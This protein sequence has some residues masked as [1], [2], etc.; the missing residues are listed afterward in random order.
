MKLKLLVIL[1]H[2]SILVCAQDKSTGRIVD[3]QTGDPIEFVTIYDKTSENHAHTDVNGNFVLKEVSAG[4]SILISMVGYTRVQFIANKETNWN[5]KMEPAPIELGQVVIMSDINA[6]SRISDVQLKLNPV[7]S[8]QEILR[9]VPGL[10]IS[11]HAGGG[12]AEQIFLR[13]FDIDHGTDIQIT[14]DGIPVNMVSHAHGQG[15]ADLHFLIPETVK[16]IDFG[17]GPYY[18]QKGNFTTA[19][20]VNFKT[21]DRIDGN[22]IKLEG[23]SFNTSRMVS[24]ID[25]FSGSGNSDGYLATE[26]LMTDGPFDS[27]QNFNRLNIFGKYT[28]Q[29]NNNFLKVQVSNFQSK[30]DAS[31]QIP[32]R[33]VEQIGRFGAIDDT[34]GGQTSRQNFLIDYTTTLSENQFVKTKAYMS[35]YDF[36]LY[37]NFTFFLEDP[38][39]GDQIKQKESRK[40][41][42]LQS[43][44]NYNTSVF[45][46]DFAIESGAGFRYDDIDGNELSHTRNRRETLIPIALADIDEVNG[47][48]FSDFTWERNKW[49]VNFGARLDQFRFEEV[50]ALQS[51][52]QRKSKTQ[53]FFSPKLNVVY[54]ANDQ[55]QF[56]A[57]TGRSFHSNDARVV[58][59]AAAI[60]TLPAALGFDLGTV[61]RPFERLFVDIAYW[62]LSLEQEFVYV[63]DGGI[64]EPSGRTKRSGID[65]GLTYQVTDNLFAYSNINYANPKSID[66][67]EGAN[68]IPLAPTFTSSGGMSYQGKRISGSIKYRYLKDR[69]ANETNSVVAQGYFVSDMNINYNRPFWSFGVSVENIFNT[70]WREAQFDTESRLSGEASSVSEIHFTPGVPF[71]LKAGLTFKF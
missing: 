2:I 53:A 50:D 51:T 10:Y 64:V 69:A 20:Y 34:E 42:G 30:W 13:G 60:N 3:G 40:I 67:V 70:E 16:G 15:Y 32:L 17:K 59:D 41:Y 65:F 19:G 46:G 62:H 22:F 7:N 31:G 63:G 23:G 58:L 29:I 45:S 24:M 21:R 28:T 5:I 33:A 8:S 61:Y 56:Y 6:I 11:Q 39:N 35:N 14:A 52:Y 25:L 1:L 4:D 55:F 38:V 43:S 47:F 9:K 49:L 54:R 66:E 27:P 26:Y 18:A 71:F 12:K 36:E 68:Y 57:K 37:S 44:Y 48:L